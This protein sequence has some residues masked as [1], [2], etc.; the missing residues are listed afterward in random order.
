MMHI[1]CFEIDVTICQAVLNSA[2]GCYLYSFTTDTL[3]RNLFVIF[4]LIIATIQQWSKTRHC[5]TFTACPLSTIY[6]LH[7]SLAH[8][9]GSS[10]PQH[11][12]LFLVLTWIN[13]YQ[14]LFQSWRLCLDIKGTFTYLDNLCKIE[15]YKMR[16]GHF[17]YFIVGNATILTP[18]LST[19]CMRTLWLQ[20]LVY[21]VRNY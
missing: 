6:F 10:F 20:I 21:T 16:V 11:V 19:T 8:R 7:A 17:L 12:N 5:F 13:Q 2:S 1:I 9:I 14:H 4:R 18:V 15:I 3:W